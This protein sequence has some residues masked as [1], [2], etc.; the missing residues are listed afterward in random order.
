MASQRPHF[1]FMRIPLG[2]RWSNCRSNRPGLQV[3]VLSGRAAEFL[4]TQQEKK[5]HN[6]TT[7]LVYFRG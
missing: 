1:I 5:K 7:Y 6:T 3:S 4:G 2:S